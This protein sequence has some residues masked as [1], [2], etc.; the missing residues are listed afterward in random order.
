MAADDRVS[1]QASGVVAG[2]FTFEDQIFKG[3]ALGA[4]FVKL[5]GMARAPIAAA[6]VGKTIGRAIDDGQLPG[7]I[8]RFGRTREE[9][10]V[11]AAALRHELGEEE[12]QRV[13][14]GALGLIT[15]YERLAQGLRQLMAGSRK[16]ATRCIAR[17]DLVA[18]THEAAEI[19]GL[20]YV[21][22][23]DREAVEALL[24]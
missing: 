6:M 11:S 12:Y 13:P 9:I 7:Y 1:C 14:G 16:F 15:Y 23:A 21:M 17:D 10:F 3:L 5:V 8:E 20:S 18:L 24:G 2:G 19:T 22:D 4:P